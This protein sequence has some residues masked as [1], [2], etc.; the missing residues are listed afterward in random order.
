[1]FAYIKG[2]LEMKF[3]NYPDSHA[4][5]V[6]ILST[7]E[8]VDMVASHM[9]KALAQLESGEKKLRFRSVM[10]KEELRAELDNLLLQKKTFPVS[11]HL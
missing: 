7:P 3:A 5:L 1:M 9:D 4:R 8:G 11:D 10:P 6:D 2:N